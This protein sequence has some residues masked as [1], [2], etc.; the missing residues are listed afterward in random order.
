MQVCTS[1]Q[2]DNHTSTPPLCFLQAGCPSCRPTNSV[3]V[4]KEMCNK[5]I[6]RDTMHTLPHYLLQEMSESIWHERLKLSC[7]IQ[8][9]K[10][11]TEKVLSDNN[12]QKHFHTVHTAH[13][14]THRMIDY[15]HLHHQQN[16]KLRS[17][18]IISAQSTFLSA[19]LS[20]VH[21][22]KRFFSLAINL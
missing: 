15:M 16:K 21:R 8:P 10:I 6:I 22:L 17:L 7:K 5:I 13:C 20:T 14:T 11:V 9:F 2:T 18:T 3:K 1:L 12:W 4:L 19:I